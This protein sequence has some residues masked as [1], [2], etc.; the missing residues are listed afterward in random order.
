MRLVCTNCDRV[1]Q[2]QRV[3]CWYCSKDTLVY[4]DQKALPAGPIASTAKQGAAIVLAA[5]DAW[6]EDLPPKGVAYRAT[7]TKRGTPARDFDRAYLLRWGDDM[8]RGELTHGLGVDTLANQYPY[9]YSR[10]GLGRVAI[11]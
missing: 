9:I 5:T 6:T 4:E 11:D 3:R 8:V 7:I 10:A 1:N 2:I